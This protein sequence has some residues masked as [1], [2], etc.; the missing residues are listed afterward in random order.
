MTVALQVHSKMFIISISNYNI[1]Y[2]GCDVYKVLYAHVARE[3]DE[4]ELVIGDFIFITQE[5]WSKTT[6]G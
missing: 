3:Q 6:D 4:L 5:E 1:Y 2:L